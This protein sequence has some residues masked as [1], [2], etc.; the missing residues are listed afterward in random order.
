MSL[1]AFLSSAIGGTLLSGVQQL[2]QEWFA[3]R[4]MR[5]ESELRLAELDKMATI[6][7]DEMQWKAFEKGQA[8]T[9]TSSWVPNSS[10]PIWLTCAFGLSEIV[11][12]LVRPLMVAF[13]FAFIWW[14]FV[15]TSGT[16][17]GELASSIQV[18]CF[19]IGYFWIG[20]RYQGKMASLLK[21]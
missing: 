12:K 20:Q 1:I 18:F 17:R 8:M 11:I 6:K 13:A 19:S 9:G 7:M 5:A 2:A 15:E 21:K 3:V 16:E 14:T 4:R 10:T